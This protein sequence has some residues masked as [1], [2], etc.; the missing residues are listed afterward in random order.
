MLV[1]ILQRRITQG[2]IRHHL[3]DSHRF[4]NDWVE[5]SDLQLNMLPCHHGPQSLLLC[6]T[7]VHNNAERR[8]Q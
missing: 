4:P 7:A 8:Q 3:I 2:N 1:Q 6:Q 5:S